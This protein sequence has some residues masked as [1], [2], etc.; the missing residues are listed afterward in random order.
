M[1]EY[2]YQLAVAFRDYDAKAVPPEV[3]RISAWTFELKKEGGMPPMVMEEI[4][5]VDCIDILPADVI[6]SSALSIR[7]DI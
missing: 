4:P 6:E 7:N 5:L 2:G 1:E 3:G